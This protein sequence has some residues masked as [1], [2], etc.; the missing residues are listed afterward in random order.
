MK[1]L[2]AGGGVKVF[3]QE[4]L[5]AVSETFAASLM[6]METKLLN[7][8]AS[9]KGQITN[10]VLLEKSKQVCVCVCVC[11]CRALRCFVVTV[12]VPPHL[13]LCV[14]SCRSNVMSLL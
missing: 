7:L 2:I 8:L 12:V 11:V 6:L 3:S 13:I 14:L 10:L 1:I 5:T 9:L 4:G